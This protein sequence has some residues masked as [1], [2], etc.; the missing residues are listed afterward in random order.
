MLSQKLIGATGLGLALVILV[1]VNTISNSSLRG[2]RMDLTESRLYTLSAGSRNIVSDLDEPITLRFFFSEKLA[3]NM[4][5]LKS[6]GTRV[7]ELLE[8]FAASS[9]GKIKL[10]VIDP[11][12][13]SE[14]EERAVAAGLQ[15]APLSRTE[16]LYFGL[17]GV[18]ST[19]LQ[20]TIPFF[21]QE[22]EQFLEYDIASLIYSL[23][24]P[25][26]K[27]V[28][29]ISPLKVEGGS[30][31]MAAMMG[32]QED[33]QPWT[34]Y[35]ALRE[36]YDVTKLENTATEIP[37]DTDVLMVIHPKDLPEPMQY[38]IDQYTLKGGKTL[39]FVDPYCEA[40]R[41]PTD[42]SNQLQAL[43][44]PRKSDMPKVLR[45]WGVEMVPDKVLADRDRG[46]EINAGSR[47]QPKIV[48][49]V[50]YGALTNEDVNRD[51]YVTSQ[52]EK[53]NVGYPGA[54]RK[55]DDAK[56]TITPLVQSS[57]KT[58]L[59]PT[60]DVQFFPDPTKLYNE[61]KS[62]DKRQI[63]G[64]QITGKATTAFPDG[65]AGGQKA[66]DHVSESTDAI[67][68]VVFSD[69]DMVTDRMWVNVQRFF[70]QQIAMP[71]ANN[72]DLVVNLVDQYSG[73]KDLI[74]IRSRGKFNRP[75]EVVEAIQKRAQET[76]AAKEAE[77]QKKVAET[78]EKLA[79]LQKARGDAASSRIL[80]PEQRAEIKKF[81]DQ[82]VETKRELRRV[83][84]AL[85]EDIEKL[86]T[87][88]KLI[89]I[90]AIPVLVGLFAVGLGWARANRR[91]RK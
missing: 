51:E 61:F 36:N 18:N 58:Q 33:E 14:A 13:F 50:L 65:P 73:S 75:F 64:A 49:F 74:G 2:T 43:T 7:R 17:E 15:G 67:N 84:L 52:L 19:D 12:P 83:Q 66:A 80:T 46:M 42:P 56:T 25:E 79:E 34:I 39:V 91:R 87:Q 41:P 76:N 45:S 78:E 71:I 30:N 20:K 81:Q 70:G 88:I 89:N 90:A 1:G 54:L 4:P 24:N 55:L 11:V 16:N 72:G 31:P 85:R 5:F 23:A 77:L 53:I 21:N 27:K 59:L 82:M 22:K 6:Y 37:K 44:A 10:E 60:S 29:I 48:N 35:S 57:E 3:S 63:I 9:K 40:D 38:A 26:K 69:V 62:D 86:G 68:V 8:E 32:Q 28:A 47:N